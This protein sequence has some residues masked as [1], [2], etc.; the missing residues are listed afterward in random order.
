MAA[1]EIDKF[2]WFIADAEGQRRSQVWSVYSR[3]DDV[4]IGARNLSQAFKLS[5]HGRGVSRDG[6]DSQLGMPRDYAMRQLSAGVPT[7]LEPARWRR[8]LPQP[9]QPALVA[10]ID[11][12]TDY[13]TAVFE[14]VTPDGK[15]K[16]VLPLAPAGGSL[17]VGVFYALQADADSAVQAHV[18]ALDTPIVK[19]DLPCGE[20][21]I[22]VAKTEPVMTLNFDLKG[23]GEALRPL[24]GAPGPGEIAVCGAVLWADRPN[25]NEAVHLVEVSGLTLRHLERAPDVP[26]RERPG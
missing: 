16:F 14:P 26:S 1:P 24:R 12:P 6:L 4:Y 11:F 9:G 23:A 8:P 18:R 19:L 15:P 7:V 5:L 13:L 10:V 21:A 3:K 2:R 17:R 22:I 25:D 20:T